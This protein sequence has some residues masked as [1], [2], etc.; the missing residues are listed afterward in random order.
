MATGDDSGNS[1]SGG[2]YSLFSGVSVA[3][4]QHLFDITPEEASQATGRGQGSEQTPSFRPDGG[5]APSSPPSAPPG[6]DQSSSTVAPPPA[7]DLPSFLSQLAGMMNTMQQQNQILLNLVQQSQA[8]ST[9]GS[10]N[11]AGAASTSTGNNQRT[12]Q[13]PIPPQSTSSNRSLS[14][15]LMPSIP[16]IDASKWTTRPHEVLGFRKYLEEIVSWLSLTD[17]DYHEE[18]KEALGFRRPL[19][20]SEMSQDQILRSQRLFHVIKQSGT[21]SGNSRWDILIRLY[22]AEHSG[23]PNGYELIRR[24]R[25]ELG[26]KTR[27][28][29]IYFRNLV[30]EF[31]FLDS[32]DLQDNIRRLEAEVFRFNQ[33]LD[34][35]IGDKSG[36]HDI[37]LQD[38]DLYQLLISC[39]TGDAKL[40]VQL[41]APET[42]AG[43]KRAC[44]VFYEKTVL[45][46]QHF[47]MSKEPLS[48]NEY[49][50]G[51]GKGHKSDVICFRCGKRG[52]ITRDC[53]VRLPDG[54]KG[55]GKGPNVS[56]GKEKGKGKQ[57]GKSDGKRSRTHSEDSRKGD[58]SSKGSPDRKGKGK[59]GK[60]KGP[61]GKRAAEYVE[62]VSQLDEAW[63]EIDPM[64]LD[65]G[66]AKSRLCVWLPKNPQSSICEGLDHRHSASLQTNSHSAAARAV[67]FDP[68]VPSGSNVPL[69]PSLRLEEKEPNQF[70]SSTSDV[71][72]LMVDAGFWLLDSGASRSVIN[73]SFLQFYKILR[74]RLLD[75]PLTFSTASGEE[76]VVTTEVIVEAHFWVQDGPHGRASKRPFELRCLVSEVQHNLLSMFQVCRQGFKCE[77][78]EEGCRVSYGDFQFGVDMFGNVPWLTASI[79]SR[80][81]L[82]K[83]IRSKAIEPSRA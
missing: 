10:Q 14:D 77:M 49:Q 24:L 55:K 39:L 68:A 78:T 82:W 31:R 15:K 42:Y 3:E 38:S 67:S 52:H 32:C 60:P 2:T 80:T 16:T 43:A 8:F 73:K 1:I 71:E 44:G 11:T 61:K 6:L 7:V 34:T 5:S 41:N 74:R 26:L 65:E 57:D 22:E 20:H 4:A 69:K 17:P 79:P 36:I 27:S 54:Q 33:M 18:V 47:D 66:H 40:Y 23:Q 58:S 83:L 64:E 45:N 19:L 37:C 46:S 62:Q 25:L 53:R 30:L 48:L 70:S 35:Y 75:E 29:C 76:M 50:A 13:T 12:Q 21:P 72:D 9:S 56:G 28:E 59:K 81:V 51:S 63:S